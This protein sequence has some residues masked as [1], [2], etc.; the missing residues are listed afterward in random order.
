[1]NIGIDA[2][3]AAEVP[4]GRG[5]VVREVLR[6]LAALPGDHAYTLYCRRPDLGLELDARFTWREIGLP[7]PFWH[8]MAGRAASR[9]CD[10][11]FSTNSY[12][13][14]WFTR[15]PSVTLVYDLVAFVEGASPQRR[16]RAIERATIRR[17]LRRASALVCISHA[18]ERDLLERF[19]EAAGKTVVVHLGGNPALARSLDAGALDQVRAR[20]GLEEPFVLSTGT[21][22]PRKNLPRLIEAF[23]GLPGELRDAHRLVLVGP[24]G[25]EMDETLRGASASPDLVKL[26]GFVPDEDLAALYRLC[27]VFCYPSLYEG[28]GLPLLEA[29]EGGA[30]AITSSVSSL[31]EVGGDAVRYVDPRDVGEIRAALEELLTSETLRAELAARGREQAARFGWERTAREMLDVLV[32][33]AR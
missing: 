1:M 8:V 19:P 22:E 11:F 21:L 2:R 15:I 5:R 27:T 24:K 23:A 12:L 10:V 26:L 25:W 32:G 28:F 7:D 31:P 16:A 6:G 29:L 20:Y 33:S 9:S 18:T 14:A 3:A 13:T 17:G 4:A 30:P